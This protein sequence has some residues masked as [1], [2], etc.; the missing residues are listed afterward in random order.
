M[1]DLQRFFSVD[2][3]YLRQVAMEM[4]EEM[5]QQGAV[6]KDY[7]KVLDLSYHQAILPTVTGLPLYL[8][9][10]VPLVM[11]AHMSLTTV[12]PGTMEMKTKPRLNYQQR[13]RVGTLC[14]FTQ[15][16]R[17]AGVQTSLN[18]TVP[19]R[20]ELSLQNGQVGSFIIKLLEITDC[21]L[22]LHHSEDS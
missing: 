13:T 11:S 6:K 17:G 12:R 18:V 16:Y 7:M 1:F 15:Q 14:P 8:H 22:D 19:I 3:D 4:A 5:S 9:H 10:R 21:L 2:S 20:T